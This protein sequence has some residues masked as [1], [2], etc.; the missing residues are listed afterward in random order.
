MTIRY[1][2][3]LSLIFLNLAA[4]SAQAAEITNIEKRKLTV[5]VPV[6]VTHP[7]DRPDP[8]GWNEGWLNNE[9]VLVDV[10][11]PV[12]RLGD[13]TR[14]RAGGTVGG[15]DN[16]IFHTSFFLGV[17]GEIETYA[18]DQLSFSLGTYAGG[19]S[20]YE[21]GLQPALTPYVGTSYAITP[22]FEM[23]LRGFWLPAETIAGSDVAPSDAYVG[24]I[25]VGTRF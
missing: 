6:Y 18:T 14:V 2:P 16:S 17:A 20:G 15:F 13:S 23:G 11:W 22:G 4:T 1:L 5:G 8:R 10:M 12:G 9:G 24:V 25:T 19:I 7:N 3:A 21:G